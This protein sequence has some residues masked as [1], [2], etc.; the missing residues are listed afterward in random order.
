MMI[1]ST[2]THLRRAAV[3]FRY[4]FEGLATKLIFVAAPEDDSLNTVRCRLDRVGQV[5]FL[6]NQGT[7]TVMMARITFSLSL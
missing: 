7:G 5:L 6:Q 3:A 1:L 2:P 4:S